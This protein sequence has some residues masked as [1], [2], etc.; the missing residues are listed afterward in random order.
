MPPPRP[1]HRVRRGPAHRGATGLVGRG[2]RRGRGGDDARAG[3]T[4]R[5]CGRRSPRRW[6]RGRATAPSFDAVFD[7]FF[8]A[9]LGSG[10]LRRPHARARLDRTRSA[11]RT[12]ARRGSPSGRGGRAAGGVVEAMAADDQEALLA[13]V[14]ESVERLGAMP[15]RPRGMSSWSSYNTLQKLAPDTL[16]LRLAQALMAGTDD[17][18]ARSEELA[19]VGAARRVDAVRRM[20]E[21]DV[22]R[23][24]AEEK[25]PEHVARTDVAAAT[26]P[27]R[28]HQRPEERHRRDAPPDLSAGTTARHPPREGAARATPRAAGLPAH[29]PRLGVDRRRTDDDAPPSEAAAPHRARRALRRQ[30]LGR[31]LRVV[32]AAA[33]LR[34]ARAVRQGPRVH[35]RRRRARGDRGVRARRRPG[36]DPDPPGGER[37]SRVAVGPH[38]LRARASC[39]SRRS[40]PTRSARSPACSSSATRAPTT[41][42]PQLATLRE[43]VDASRH[44]WWLNPEAR[45]AVG[46]RRLRRARSTARWCRWSSAA[47]SPS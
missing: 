9:L 45:A 43:M 38:R 34:A 25:D 28:V 2:P 7:L 24:I 41:P 26:R 4:G 5:A 32:H 47:T 17:R 31:Q 29:R 3:A 35:L 46:H 19:M 36:G 30:R 10:A 37:P 6:S 12:Y 42:I 22:R 13:L 14:R 1:A 21:S 15:G 20:V 16:V 23:R 11:V 44:A 27:D 39:S 18:A 40:T 33:R 8:P